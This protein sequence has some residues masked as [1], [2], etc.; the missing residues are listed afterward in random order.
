LEQLM[1]RTRLS[2][3]AAA[4]VAL[5]AALLLAGCGGGDS[6]S[7]GGSGGAAAAGSSADSAVPDTSGLLAG[8][9][10]DSALAQGLPADLTS[11]AVGSNVQSPPNNFYAEDGKTPVGFEVDI[12]TAIGKKLGLDVKYSDMAF[13]SLITSLQTG[14]VDTTIAGMNDTKERQGSIDFVDYFTSGITIMVQKG[15]PAKIKASADLCGKSIAVVQGTTQEDF[16]AQQSGECQSAGKAALKVTATPSDSQNQT[17]LRTGRVDAILNDLPTAVYISKTAGGGKYFQTV[18][19]DPINGG[20]YGIGVSKDDTALRD[21]IKQALQSLID[22]GTYGK[23]L[24]AWDV[25][26]GA[27]DQA[28]V[29]GG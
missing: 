6:A 17:Q 27:V 7:A 4:P 15:N 12:I 19:Q 25:A 22:D 8:V 11:L 20:P 18:D 5:T 3:R 1:S 13:D 16:A 9:K 28:T 24:A 10:K 23:I 14:R 26:S 21:G 29:N 2:V